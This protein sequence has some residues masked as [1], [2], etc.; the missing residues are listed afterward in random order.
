MRSRLFQNWLCVLLLLLLEI[1]LKSWPSTPDFFPSLVTGL[2]KKIHAAPG[3]R[4]GALLRSPSRHVSQVLPRSILR[5]DL[6]TRKADMGKQAGG[7][8]SVLQPRAGCGLVGGNA[9][10]TAY[11]SPKVYS[12]FGINFEQLVNRWHLG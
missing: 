6:G 2:G 7:S 5:K 11:Q 12:G 3:S 8:C 1:L 9:A 4:C 10:R